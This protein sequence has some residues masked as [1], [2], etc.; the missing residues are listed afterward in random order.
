MLCGFWMRARSR[1]AHAFSVGAGTC[2]GITVF[3]AVGG[4]KGAFGAMLGPAIS[5]GGGS[6][7]GEE[8]KIEFLS[9]DR[10]PLK[11]KYNELNWIVTRRKD[12]CRG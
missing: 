10:M 3:S 7:N 12:W 4:T 1:L 8:P 11:K 6:D 9:I 5:D 2:L